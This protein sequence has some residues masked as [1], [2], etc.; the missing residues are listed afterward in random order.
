MAKYLQGI[1]GVFIGKV[2]TVVGCVWKGIPYMRSK[3]N[4]R[5]GPATES[6]LKNRSKFAAAHN[7]LQP[8]LVFLRSGFAGYTE[9]VTGFNAAKS[10]NLKNA[11]LNGQMIPELA[12]VSYGDLPLSEEISVICQDAKLHFNWS[13]AELP[14][15]SLK[16]QIMVLAYHPESKVAIFDTQG[17]FR[18]MGNQILDTYSEFAGKTVH[19]YAAF[20]AADRGK[21]S[22]S[23]YLG[24]INC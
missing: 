13:T 12:K 24:A 17:A 3:G 5:T 19:V 18:S 23:H 8:L 6:E 22:D 20:V 16:D 7:W 15:A 21:Q 1:N 14:G 2:G 9:T 4:Q 11:M 10:Y